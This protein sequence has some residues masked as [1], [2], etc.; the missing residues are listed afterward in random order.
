MTLIGLG[1][2]LVY[3]GYRL[4]LTS[5]HSSL[6]NSTRKPILYLRAFEDDGRHNLNPHSI[7]AKLLGVRPF[8]WLERLGPFAAAYPIRLFK[9]MVGA[10]ADTS[11][12]QLGSC[13]RKYGPFVTYGK[14]GEG[15]ALGGADRLYEKHENW[16]Q[17]IIN[18][19]DRSRAVVLQ[20]GESQGVW[21][22]IATLTSR[23]KPE[24]LLL[25]LVNF[26]NTQQGYDE[27]R[28]RFEDQI[29]HKLPRTLSGAHFMCFHHDWR[30]QLL[31]SIDRSPFLWPL[32]GVAVDLRISR[33]PERCPGLRPDYA[34][35]R[36]AGAD[37]PTTS[38]R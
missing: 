7:T 20:P 22:E 4:G 3:I 24:Q 21:W 33:L 13:F 26:A 29:G 12:E 5:A 2:V 38:S 34:V 14:P 30:P 11:E 37:S 18:L 10:A 19:A 1:A 35:D 15:L 31:P 23:L 36:E 6:K 25:C 32:V 8:S 28:L 9:L 27:F 17:A 16:Q